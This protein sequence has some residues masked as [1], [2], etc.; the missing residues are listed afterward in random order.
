MGFKKY[1]KNL[2]FLRSSED[3]F[4]S[5]G[6]EQEDASEC[7]DLVSGP[8]QFNKLGMVRVA[9]EED[10][11]DAPLVCFAVLKRKVRA[12]DPNDQPS[13]I[14]AVGD[15]PQVLIGDMTQITDSVG[16]SLPSSVQVFL[17]TSVVATTA[18]HHHYD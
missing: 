6:H 12:D 18:F 10:L 14:V 7:E 9:L 15:V 8:P 2:S 13:S 3:V 17:Q 16:L 11:N 1:L 5:E 4:S